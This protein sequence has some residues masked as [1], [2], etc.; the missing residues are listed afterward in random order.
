MH[1]DC[2]ERLHAGETVSLTNAE[3]WISEPIRNGRSAPVGLWATTVVQA[4]RSI[5]TPLPDVRPKTLWGLRL[6]IC[7]TTF[8]LLQI[9][10]VS[11]SAALSVSARVTGFPDAGSVTIETSMT[12]ACLA[13]AEDARTPTSRRP[14]M[15]AHARRGRWDAAVIGPLCDVPRSRSMDG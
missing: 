15:S 10:I 3:F 14:R 12:S 1:A 7:A 4:P 11:P 8:D 6:K 2:V 9:L 13:A 5:F